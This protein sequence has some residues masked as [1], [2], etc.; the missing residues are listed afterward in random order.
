[1]VRCRV[2]CAATATNTKLYSEQDDGG[3]GK[4]SGGR[5]IMWCGVEPDLRSVERRVR[6]RTIPASIVAALRC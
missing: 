1:M 5:V 4:L 3:V 6:C 2:A